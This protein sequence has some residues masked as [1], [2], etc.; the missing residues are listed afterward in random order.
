[1]RFFRT[2]KR[3]EKSLP[4]SRVVFK[5]YLGVRSKLKKKKRTI[6][7]SREGPSSGRCKETD[8][9]KHGTE[10]NRRSRRT[11]EVK[12]T[13]ESTVRRESRAAH[14]TDSRQPS[15]DYEDMNPEENRY[16]RQRYGAYLGENPAT[17]MRSVGSSS[18]AIL[19]YFRYL[20]VLRIRFKKTS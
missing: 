17:A 8:M 6:D 15:T 5:L 3:F 19:H 13:H 7:T 18:S 14:L 9:T 10:I 1:M 16:E 20:F 2:S 4:K 11:S 12:T